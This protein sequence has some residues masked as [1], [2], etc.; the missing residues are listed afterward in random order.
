MAQL[1]KFK[2]NTAAIE[3]GQWITLRE[4][5]GLRIKTRGFTDAYRDNVALRRRR[6]AADYGN[7]EVRI[8]ARVQ[9]EITIE[10]LINDL[11]LDVADLTGPDG[12]PVTF[13]AFCN[14]LRDPDYEELS[15]ACVEAAQQVGRRGQRDKAEAA[16]PLEPTASTP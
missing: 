14:L 11:L 4:Y 7:D 16:G 15:L 1:T 12:Q 3:G 5:D 10:G 13:E 6:A 2:R 9:R 8:P